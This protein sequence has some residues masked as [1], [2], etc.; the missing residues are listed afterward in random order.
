MEIDGLT[1]SAVQ[2]GA[3]GLEKGDLIVAIDGKSTRYMPLKSAVNLIKSVKAD[4]VKLTLRRN[5]IIWRRS[6]I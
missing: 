3:A 5:L 6:E 2:D 4:A 1:V